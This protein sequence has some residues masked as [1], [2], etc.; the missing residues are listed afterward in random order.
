MCTYLRELRNDH[1]LL[2]VLKPGEK[3]RDSFEE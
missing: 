3:E 2:A 1:F